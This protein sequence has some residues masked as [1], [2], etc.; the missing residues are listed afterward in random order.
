MQRLTVEVFNKGKFVS[1]HQQLSGDL[2]LRVLASRESIKEHTG[3]PDTLDRPVL[4]MSYEGILA[5][6]EYDYE[7]DEVRV[8]VL[9]PDEHQ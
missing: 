1:S 6:P 3:D 8:T 2:L 9:A 7:W 4:E 5:G